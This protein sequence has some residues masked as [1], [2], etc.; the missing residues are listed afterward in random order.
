MVNRGEVRWISSD[1]PHKGR[2]GIVMT[3]QAVAGRLRSV[4]VAPVT[5][6]IRN[7][8]SE[9]LLGPEHGLPKRCVASLD[10]LS[11]VDVDLLGAVIAE[12][13]AA[14][15]AALCTALATAVDCR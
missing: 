15:M 6:Q 1:E 12:L 14:T 8:P 13:D 10:N 9:V 3:R 2:P 7:L 11:L 4:L 5:T